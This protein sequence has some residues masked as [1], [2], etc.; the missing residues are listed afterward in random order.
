MF[1]ANKVVAAV[2]HRLMGLAGCVKGKE[3]ILL[4][5]NLTVAAFTD[6]KEVAVGITEKVPFLFESKL[7]EHGAVHESGNDWYQKVCVN[8]K[9]GMGQ[10]QQSSKLC[11]EK[12]VELLG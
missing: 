4:I 3:K 12:V 11:T 2:C 7:K 5:K 8:C 9:L 10:N 1:A 6:N